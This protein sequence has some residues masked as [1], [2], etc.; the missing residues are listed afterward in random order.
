MK[1]I[2]RERT[3]LENS[4]S[5]EEIYVWHSAQLFKNNNRQMRL[6]RKMF[7]NW[8]KRKVT[9]TTNRRGII[10]NN[11]K[12]VNLETRNIGDPPFLVFHGRPRVEN[13]CRRLILAPLAETCGGSAAACTAGWGGG[14]RGRS[15]TLSRR[16]M[17]RRGNGVSFRRNWTIRA[18]V[19][20]NSNSFKTEVVTRYRVEEG[21][22][23]N[24]CVFFPS[25]RVP[26]RWMF[27]EI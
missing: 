26:L 4:F 24:A 22:N 18:P 21:N 19:L 12:L 25:T 17:H 3:D 13:Y 8:K 14:S 15:E 10:G 20:A 5:S 27:A 9:G 7:E 6:I 1:A 16:M 2:P 23:A 11:G